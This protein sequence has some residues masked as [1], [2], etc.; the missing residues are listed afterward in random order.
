VTG[1]LLANEFL[2]ALPVHLVEG[3]GGRLREIYV[4]MDGEGRLREKPGDPSS[5]EVSRYFDELGL[6]LAEGQRA[7]VNLAALRFIGEAA[8]LLDAGYATI[9]DYG[10]EAPEL[11]SERHFAGTLV[12]YR[13]HQLVVD[14]LEHPGAQDMTAHVDFT[15]IA[16]E[17]RRAGFDAWAMTSQRNLLISM[18]LAELIGGL[19]TA[20]P[21]EGP[22]GEGERLRRRF[23]LHALMSPSGM[24]ETFKVMILSK[25]APLD[26]LTCLM[27]RFRGREAEIR[28][29]ARVEAD[30]PER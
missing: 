17:G 10:H 29:S 11:F 5:S 8:G 4:E 30:R 6:S 1:C 23:A 16:R 12:G 18:G 28:S 14:P 24:G 9:I 27:D 7:E 19:A 21:A 2:D 13:R 22:A 3:C 15:S 26:G 25:R 20:A